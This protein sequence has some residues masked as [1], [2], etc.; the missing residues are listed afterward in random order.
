M[1]SLIPFLYIRLAETWQRQGPQNDDALLWKGQRKRKG[2]GKRSWKRQ[3]KGPRKELA[4]W[5]L[6]KAKLLQIAHRYN[7][8]VDAKLV[9]SVLRD[10]LVSSHGLGTIL[11]S[12]PFS[13]TI[14]IHINDSISPTKQRHAPL[15]PRRVC[16]ARA[17]G[18]FT[19]PV[20]SVL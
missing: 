11:S 13:D 4:G 15:L 20:Q 8:L 14:Y 16:I 18:K 12:S 6:P 2:Q 1:A 10:V 3:R 7:V 19:P 5:V 9:L 17:G